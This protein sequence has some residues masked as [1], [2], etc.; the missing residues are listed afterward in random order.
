MVHNDTI[1][2]ITFDIAARA[3]VSD[4]TPLEL[5]F[6][7]ACKVVVRCGGYCINCLITTP[8]VGHAR[9]RMKDGEMSQ[10]FC[11][12]AKHLKIEVEHTERVDRQLDDAAVRTIEMLWIM[13]I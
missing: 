2:C 12:C 13:G 8:E 4:R 10:W 6:L 7:H 1:K 3:M 9:M 5:Q 11:M